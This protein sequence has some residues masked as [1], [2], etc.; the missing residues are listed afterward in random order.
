MWYIYNKLTRVLHG[1]AHFE[2][3]PL[4]CSDL[5]AAFDF[6]V[7][8]LTASLFGCALGALRTVHSV[9]LSVNKLW[10]ILLNH[11]LSSLNPPSLYYA[12]NM[13]CF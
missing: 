10:R 3:F 9:N 12:K 13:R 1:K 11:M 7:S 6:T 2:A 8:V 4:S 5:P